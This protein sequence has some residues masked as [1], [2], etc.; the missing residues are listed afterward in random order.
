MSSQH[1]PACDGYRN[2]RIL[3][4]CICDALREHG[5][6]VLREWVETGTASGRDPWVTVHHH[7]QM[8]IQCSIGKE[9]FNEL[10]QLTHDPVRTADLGGSPRPV[11]GHLGLDRIPTRRVRSGPWGR[12]T[13][14][15]FSG[16]SPA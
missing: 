1:L 9:G 3:D 8:R 6:S 15:A 5:T 2:P 10:F 7:A 13:T 11:T 14:G 16:R 4:E 12:L